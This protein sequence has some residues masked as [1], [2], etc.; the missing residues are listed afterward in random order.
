MQ[1]VYI[2]PPL[3]GGGK[4]TIRL[5]AG[6]E[7]LVMTMYAVNQ[8][9]ARSILRRKAAEIIAAGVPEG[10]SNSVALL[11]AIHREAADIIDGLRDTTKHYRVDDAK[12]FSVTFK[13]PV[14]ESV[15]QELEDLGFEPQDDQIEGDETWAGEARLSELE[16]LCQTWP[17]CWVQGETPWRP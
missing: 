10:T 3:P 14:P 15:V 6:V 17:A 9:E 7:R 5:T 13:K 16:S 2:N 12:R 8:A 4:T 11:D 1:Y